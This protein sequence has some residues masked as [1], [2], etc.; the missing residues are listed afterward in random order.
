MPTSSVGIDILDSSGEVQCTLE[1]LHNCNL[2]SSW[3]PRGGIN[4]TATWRG[5][6]SLFLFAYSFYLFNLIKV[7]FY[8][9]LE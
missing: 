9:K 7:I 8:L 4:I 1:T 6:F 2:E 5:F 3:L